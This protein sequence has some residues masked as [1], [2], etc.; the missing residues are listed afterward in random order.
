MPDMSASASLAMT[1][2]VTLAELD[3]DKVTPGVLGFIV[4]AVMALAVWGLMKSMNRHMGKVD[5]TEAPDPESEASGKSDRA[6]GRVEPQ[7]G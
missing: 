1:H 5:F 2:L 4:F 3:E 6:S 7:Q